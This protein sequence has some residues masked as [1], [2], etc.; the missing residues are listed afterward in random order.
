MRVALETAEPAGRYVLMK[1]AAEAGAQGGNLAL[2]WSATCE[3]T[4]RFAVPERAVK[5]QTLE[6]LAAHLSGAEDRLGIAHLA[7]TESRFAAK[8]RDYAGALRLISLAAAESA[9]GGEA[10]QAECLRRREKNLEEEK[11][12]YEKA[13]QARQWLAWEPDAPQP[14]LTAGKF[15]CFIEGDWATGLPFLRKAQDPMLTT[16]AIRECEGRQDG[17]LLGD[18]W[19]RVGKQLNGLSQANAL[20]RATYWYKQVLPELKGLDLA[21]ITARLKEMMEADGRTAP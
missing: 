1:E 10:R 2:A 7:E 6:L 4:A 15:H 17:L 3:L 16:L 9:K 14:N 5:L 13:R 19:W 21:R 12:E 18:G 11:R 20:A 8:A